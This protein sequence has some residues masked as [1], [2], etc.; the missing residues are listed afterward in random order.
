MNDQRLLFSSLWYAGS[1]TDSFKKMYA[2]EPTEISFSKLPAE[3]L[4][5]QI[6]WL[7]CFFLPYYKN[8]HEI[9]DKIISTNS[10]HKLVQQW[11]FYL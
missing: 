8:H 5:I 6:R 2:V 11:V 4:L 9:L 7:V 10:E 1:R 3:P